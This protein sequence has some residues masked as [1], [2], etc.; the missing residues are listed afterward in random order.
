MKK[1]IFAFAVLPLLSFGT[2]STDIISTGT[3]II[4]IVDKSTIWLGA[5]SKQ[6]YKHINYGYTENLNICKLYHEK[7]MFFAVSGIPWATINNVRYNIY[8]SIRQ[9]IRNSSNIDDALQL[10]NKDINATATDVFKQMVNRYPKIFLS[11]LNNIIASFII[12]GSENGIPVYVAVDYKLTG[13]VNNWKITNEKISPVK[14]IIALG[15]R[16]LIVSYVNRTFKNNAAF[17]NPKDSI[18]KYIKMAIT[19]Y[20]TEVGLPINIIKFDNKGYKWIQKSQP[21]N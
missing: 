4:C 8:E 13:D 19:A 1:L 16:Q 7:N 9:G 5:D 12:C 20:P 10:S 6:E 11:R 18:N 14:N 15:K 3:S 17:F 21:C 2:K